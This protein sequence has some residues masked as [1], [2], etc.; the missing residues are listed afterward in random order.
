MTARSTVTSTVP[1]YVNGHFN[2]NVNVIDFAI[3]PHPLRKFIR[4]IGIGD[5]GRGACPPNLGKYFS[6]NCVKFGHFPGKIM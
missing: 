1:R 4:D 6:G 5:G 3:V 2:V